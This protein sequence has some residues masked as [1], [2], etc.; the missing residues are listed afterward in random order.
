MPVN[1]DTLDVPFRVHILTSLAA[2]SQSPFWDHTVVPRGDEFHGHRDIYR[3][4]RERKGKRKRNS[5]HGEWANKEER[6]KGNRERERGVEVTGEKW[7]VRV[8]PGKPK[9][10]GLLCVG[11]YDARR[12]VACGEGRTLTL[13]THRCASRTKYTGVYGVAGEKSTGLLW[14]FRVAA[15]AAAVASCG[16]GDG[17]AGRGRDVVIRERKFQNIAA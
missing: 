12:S 13:R 3:A 9:Q 4:A 6:K 15:A 5:E 16:D 2:D 17:N 10:T 11:A 14:D 7:G 1:N 8:T